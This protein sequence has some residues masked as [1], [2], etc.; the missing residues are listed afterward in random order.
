MR[1]SKTITGDDEDTKEAEVPKDENL[2]E[3]DIAI[4]EVDDSS[5]D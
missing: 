5:N 2:Q 3:E 1:L 4:V